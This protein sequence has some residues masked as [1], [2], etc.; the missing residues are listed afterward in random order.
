MNE[1]KNIHSYYGR[2]LPCRRIL[3]RDGPQNTRCLGAGGMEEKKTALLS[4][5]RELFATKGFKDT[6]VA[7][8]TGQ[9]GFS[10][11]TFYNYYPS[12]DRL[13]VEILK[14]ETAALMKSIM[15]SVDL[16]DDPVK[17]IKRLLALNQEGMRSNPILSQWYQPGVADRIEK[18][19][20]EEN[21]L[22]A[23]D[24]LYRDFLELVRKWQA[25]GRM[26]SDI[27]G[28]MIMAIFEAIIR[29][30]Y[31][32]EEIGL[33]YFPALQDHLTDF[34]LQGLTE[35]AGEKGGLNREP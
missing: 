10:V 3:K 1:L 29:I 32:K 33:Q 23:V 24:F 21:G 25:E 6:N 14:Q 22:Q 4:C 27:S 5:A 30:G 11:G 16:D 26:R 2:I 8:I 15:K 13:F 18:I 31:R 19:F 34:V 20:R 9:A 35:C 17:L 28:E 12:K 7:D